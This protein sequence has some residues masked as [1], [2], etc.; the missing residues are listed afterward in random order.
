MAKKI[1]TESLYSRKEIKTSKTTDQL[2]KHKEWH[3]KWSKVVM[4]VFGVSLWI[5]AL[6]GIFG[7]GYLVRLAFNL[8]VS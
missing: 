5:L 7:V 6:G 1:K 2:Q 4:S 8:L 3:E